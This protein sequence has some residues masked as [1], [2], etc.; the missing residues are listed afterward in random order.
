MDE[1]S[2]TFWS[3]QPWHKS[4]RVVK[5]KRYGRSGGMVWISDCGMNMNPAKWIAIDEPGESACRVCR[6][7]LPSTR[8]HNGW[9]DSLDERRRER[10]ALETGY[11]AGI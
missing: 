1:K 4:H 10:E 5:T 9:L 11:G 3:W 6:G 2:L 8:A 7:N